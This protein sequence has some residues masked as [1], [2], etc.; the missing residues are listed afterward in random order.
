MKYPYCYGKG[1]AWERVDGVEYPYPCPGCSGSGE[2]EEDG[3][4]E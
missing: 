2:V 3:E 1:A 4:N